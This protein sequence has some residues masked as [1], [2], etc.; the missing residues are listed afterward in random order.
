MSFGS[1]PKP[2]DPNASA[3]TQLGFNTQAAQA[4]Q[5]LNMIN[6][7]TPFGSLSYASDPNAPGGYSANVALSPQQQQL[8]NLQQGSQRNTGGAANKLT[9]NFG[10]LYGSPPDLSAQTGQTASMLNKWQQQYLAPIFQQQQSNTDAQLQNQ[11]LTPGSTAYNN[12]ENLLARNQ[13]DIT[14]Q[15]LSMNEPT[16]FSQ[17]VTQYQ[18]P[19]QT[20]AGLMANSQ[21]QGPSFQQTPQE[22]IAAPNYQQAAQNQYQGNQANYATQQQGM[23]NAIGAGAGLAMMPFTGGWA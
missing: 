5:G 13:G 17:A 14:N 4:Q 2:V 15:Y 8:L 18:L 21:P 16:A 7:Q 23:W 20:A 6:Q 11:G 10:G 3:Q 1:A 9:S 12:A 19:M 22:Q